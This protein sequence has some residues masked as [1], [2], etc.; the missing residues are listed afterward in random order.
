MKIKLFLL[1]VSIVFTS[2]KNDQKNKNQFTMNLNNYIE[3]EVINNFN[4]ITEE[5]K[6]IL[7]EITEYIQ[8]KVKEKQPIQLVYICT[9]NSRRSHFGQIWSQIAAHY[10][11]IDHVKTF[12]GGTE[13]TAFNPRAVKAIE[14]TGIVIKKNGEQNPKYFL[15]YAKGK[16]PITCFS[17]RYDDALNPKSNFAAIMTCSDADQNCPFVEGADFRIATPY[18]DP[19]IADN[20]AKETDKYDER[21]KQIATEVFYTFSLIKK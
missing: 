12:S 15:N 1:S 11:Q 17:K 9:H 16:E 21:C 14:R 20:T 2:F 3:N 5:R 13:A 7:Q 19:K 4:S 8:L 10:Y 6:K 18:E